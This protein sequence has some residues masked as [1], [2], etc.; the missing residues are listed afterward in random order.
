MA[1]YGCF[2]GNRL[3]YVRYMFYAVGTL[4]SKYPF[5]LFARLTDTSPKGEEGAD[6]VRLSLTSGAQA[7]VG[8]DDYIPTTALRRPRLVVNLGRRRLT[9]LTG[10]AGMVHTEPPGDDGK[11]GHDDNQ[12]DDE[13]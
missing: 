12:G 8:R 11:A 5:R 1:S 13:V 9:R 3:S 10:R 4:R 2:G 7:V 6:L